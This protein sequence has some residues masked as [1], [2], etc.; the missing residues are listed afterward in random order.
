MGCFVPSGFNFPKFEDTA[1]ERRDWKIENCIRL[2][3]DDSD[4]GDISHC[5]NV[6]YLQE[7][8]KALNLR[9]E[10][11]KKFFGCFDFNVLP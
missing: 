9:A 5:T 2:Y 3:F 10:E 4:F 11:V 1:Y 6:R 7:K 8:G